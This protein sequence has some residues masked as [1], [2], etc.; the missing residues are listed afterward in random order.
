MHL[1]DPQMRL[2]HNPNCSLREVSHTHIQRIKLPIQEGIAPFLGA[3]FPFKQDSTGHVRLDVN[4]LNIAVSLGERHGVP[5]TLTG[6]QKYQVVEGNF[7]GE[8]VNMPYQ[9]EADIGCA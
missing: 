3:L 5:G 8:C 6:Q 2:H 1:P 7:L 9:P 4:S